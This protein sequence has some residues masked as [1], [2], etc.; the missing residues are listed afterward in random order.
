[1]AVTPVDKLK[2]VYLVHGSEELLIERQITSLKTR[3]GESAD[4]DFNFQSF[5]GPQH[6]VDEIIAAANTMPFMS[7]RRLIVVRDVDHMSAEAKEAL[8]A[9]MDDPAPHTCLLLVAT[10]LAKNTRLYKA[11]EKVGTAVEFASLKPSEY[12][13]EVIRMFE[14]RG[15]KVDRDAAQALV[16]AVGRDLRALRSEVDKLVTHAGPKHRLVKDDILE[17][18]SETSPTSIFDFV[19]AVGSRDAEDSLRLLSRLTAE[20]ESVLRLHAMAVRH[21]RDLIG[22]RALVDRG[23]STGEMMSALGRP[24]WIVRKLVGQAERFTEAELVDALRTAAKSEA[25]MKTSRVPTRLALE[26]WVISVCEGA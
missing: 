11:V 22:T 10:K 24:D 26:R 2:P 21:V 8:V 6:E 23:A 18:V 5:E 19:D 20:G 12:S 14:D 4:L 7:D 9:Y 17:V 16:D 1:M 13:R 15:K 3:I 25:Q